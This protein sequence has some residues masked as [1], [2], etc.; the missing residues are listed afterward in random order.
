MRSA[1]VVVVGAGHNGL[2]AAAYLAKAG[3]DVLVVEAFGTPGGMT[4]TNPMAPE[5]PEYLINEASLQASLFRTT[6]IDR[7]LRLG[8]RAAELRRLLAGAVARPPAHR[9]RAQELLAEGRRRA[10]GPVPG[11]RRRRGR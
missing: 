5:A 3:L 7:D 1:D 10:A 4:S 9:R 2:V 11:D 6:S 8:A